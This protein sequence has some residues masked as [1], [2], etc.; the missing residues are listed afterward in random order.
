MAATSRTQVTSSLKCSHWSAQVWQVNQV[1]FRVHTVASDT[2]KTIDGLTELYPINNVQPCWRT[3]RRMYVRPRSNCR[4]LVMKWL[5]AFIIRCSFSV[6]DFSTPASR[7]GTTDMKTWTKMA[8]VSSSSDRSIR[9]RW[10]SWKKQFELI[11]LCFYLTVLQFC[12]WHSWRRKNQH[13]F[14]IN[15]L[16]NW[17]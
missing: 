12:Y 15:I 6:V 13:D 16:C 10:R 17:L 7:H 2:L 4:V 9:R 5:A 11:A 8:T 14:R 1:P 3:W